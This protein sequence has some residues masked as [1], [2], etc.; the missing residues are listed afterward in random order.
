MKTSLVTGAGGFIG[1]H[2]CR[3]LL[4]N[5]PDHAIVAIDLLT[6]AGTEENIADLQ[7]HPHFCF[8]KGDIGDREW[9]RDLFETHGFT[10]VINLAAE[11]HVDRSILDPV[12]FVRTNVE[13]TLVL[14]QE[15]LKAWGDR[16]DVLF[17]HVSTD[18]VFGALG[19]TGYFKE[20]TPYAPRSPYAASKASADHLV[21]AAGETYGLPY[22]ISHAANNYGPNQFPEKLIP[23]T[24]SK[25]LAGEPVP[26]YGKGENVRDWLFVRDHCRAIATV[27]DNGQLKESYCIGSDHELRNIDLVQ[28]LLDELDRARGLP[29]GQSRELISFVKDRP[30]HDFRYAMDSSKVEALGWKPQIGIEEGLRETVAWYLDNQEWSQRALE[31]AN[32]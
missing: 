13:G 28:N 26:V 11:T 23:L 14:I 29:I 9:I 19:P 3:H 16:D 27:L 6:Y 22:I 24:I 7:N 12:V 15:A 5:E 30:G 4:E 20:S 2:L 21:R 8:K 18:E 32:R 17:Y 25:V 10:R 1:S 31:R